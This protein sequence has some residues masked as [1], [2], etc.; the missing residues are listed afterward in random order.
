MRRRRLEL[1]VALLALGALSIL[2]PLQ[3]VVTS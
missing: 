3:V 1:L 2:V